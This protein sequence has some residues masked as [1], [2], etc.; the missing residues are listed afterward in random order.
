MFFYYSISIVVWK[1]K[2]VFYRYDFKYYI[3]S[4]ELFYSSFKCLGVYGNLS[5]KEL[6]IKLLLGLIVFILFLRIFLEF[7]II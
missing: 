1:G 3:N 7:L 2:V 6:F 5:K 4:K